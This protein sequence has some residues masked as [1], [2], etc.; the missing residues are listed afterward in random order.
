VAISGATGAWA[1]NN[2][3]PAG[4]HHYH[5]AVLKK[6]LVNRGPHKHIC[7]PFTLHRFHTDT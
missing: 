7:K 4:G 6:T 2:R 3:P 5:A 1:L